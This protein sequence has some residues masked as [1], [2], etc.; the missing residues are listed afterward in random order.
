MF[1]KAFGSMLYKKTQTYEWYSMFK[2]GRNADED[3]SS[4]ATSNTE[5]NLKKV[6]KIVLKNDL[7]KML[8]KIFLS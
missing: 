1:S 7:L 2:N 3:F 6:K 4:T 8:Q 5:K